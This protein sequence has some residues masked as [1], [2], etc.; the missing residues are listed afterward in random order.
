MKTLDWKQRRFNFN[1]LR[2]FAAVR[3]DETSAFRFLQSIQVVPYEV[4]RVSAP[5]YIVTNL[6]PDSIPAGY[7]AALA[8]EW[9]RDGPSS[10]L[11][12]VD[13]LR[14]EMNG[15]HEREAVREQLERVGQ[16]LQ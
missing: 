8:Y 1:E 5:D 3:T 7:L 12:F 16:E 2:Q 10:A 15:T 13:S 9:D 11:E 4:K 6:D 14:P